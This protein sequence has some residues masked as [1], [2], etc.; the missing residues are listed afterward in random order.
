MVPIFVF[1][2][3]GVIAQTNKDIILDFLSKSFDQPVAKMLEVSHDL[4]RAR[5][6]GIQDRQFWIEYATS[7]GITLPPCWFDQLEEIQIIAI[8]TLPGMIELVQHLQSLG[9]QIAML[10]N[11]REEQARLVRKLELYR[12]FK[13]KLSPILR[14][15]R[16]QIGRNS[17]FATNTK[18]RLC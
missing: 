16:R 15:G 13:P 9:Y 6:R 14:A 1:D 17:R 7:Q 12:Y 18:S 10:S 8:Q 2:F 5:T 4:K 11:V 3:G